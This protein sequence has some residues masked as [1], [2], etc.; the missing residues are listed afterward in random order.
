M[1]WQ[2]H[3]HFRQVCVVWYEV[4]DDQVSKLNESKEQVHIDG[5]VLIFENYSK[6]SKMIW[7]KRERKRSI[8]LDFYRFTKFE[9]L[10]SSILND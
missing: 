1:D 9:T 5:T 10:K 8:R 2:I 4:S 3:V 6:L 7:I